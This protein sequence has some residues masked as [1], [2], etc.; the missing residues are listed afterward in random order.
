MVAVEQ[1]QSESTR[2]LAYTH[3]EF[4]ELSIRIS[5]TLELLA[6]SRPLYDYF[7]H[8]SERVTNTVESSWLK[9]VALEK[10]FPD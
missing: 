4:N 10:F 5:N 2:Q 1:I 3:N 7:I 9:L 8:P 6:D